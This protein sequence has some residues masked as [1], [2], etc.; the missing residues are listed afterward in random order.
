MLMLGF[1]TK[2]MVSGQ[3]KFEEGRIVMLKQ[4]MVFIPLDFFVESTRRIIN[5]NDRKGMLNI[6]LDA[7]KS[8]FVF[9]ETVSELYKMKKFEE[10]YK[11]AMDIIS[12]A[13]FGDYETMQFKRGEYSHFKITNNSI[14]EIFHPSKVFVDH[15]LRGFNA[16]GG[17]P[18]HGRIIN[19]IETECKAINGSHCIHINANTEILKKFKDQK[20]VESQL[21]LDYLLEEEKKFLK[22][23]K[24]KIPV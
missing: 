16:G 8:G 5:N 19:T 24:I 23:K 15:V 4:P 10:R 13:G 2:L 20:L 9:M 7:W 11:I 17:T 1:L 6:Y 3:L 18:V 22:E 21:D 12:M 14:A